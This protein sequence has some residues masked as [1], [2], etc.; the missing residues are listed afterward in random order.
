MPDYIAFI[1]VK[2]NALLSALKFRTLIKGGSDM[3]C[4]LEMEELTA[5]HI[6]YFYWI[7]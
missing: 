6:G 4:K 2:L 5:M 3:I 7:C 1:Q